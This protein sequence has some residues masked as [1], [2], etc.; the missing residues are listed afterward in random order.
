MEMNTETSMFAISSLKS[1]ELIDINTGAKLGY[2]KDFKVNCDEHR[3][4]AIIIP[5]QKS[6]WFSKH[7][8]IEIPWDKIKKIGIDV[9]LIDAD[10]FIENI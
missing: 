2:I 3:I 1:M 8:D 9:I 10:G 4:E 6:G 5:M 7:E